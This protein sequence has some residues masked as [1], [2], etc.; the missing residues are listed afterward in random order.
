MNRV[1]VE[2]LAEKVGRK[3]RKEFRGGR[4]GGGGFLIEISFQVTSH[5][6]VFGFD[7]FKAF[8]KV[9][10]GPRVAVTTSVELVGSDVRWVS[11]TRER[12]PS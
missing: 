7:S 1:S 10:G 9:E 4:G 6:T 8:E 2:K 12:L 5:A 11:L 3:F